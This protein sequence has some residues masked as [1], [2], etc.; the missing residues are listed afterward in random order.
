MPAY[1]G[2][3]PSPLPQAPTENPWAKQLPSLTAAPSY[4]APVPLPPPSG[5][6]AERLAE[7]KEHAADRKT[8]LRAKYRTAIM[9]LAPAMVSGK[10]IS[11][12]EMDGLLALSSEL[13][14]APEQ[15]QADLN[16]A[17]QIPVL[18]QNVIAERQAVADERQERESLGPKL[19][20]A[21][22]LVVNLRHRRNAMQHRAT[23][24]A[25]LAGEL[26]RAV[27]QSPRVFDESFA[28]LDPMS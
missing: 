4:E 23:S 14:F 20:E 19:K 7:L 2:T 28:K 18:K 16:S 5:A 3:L 10:K 21:E 15:M 1:P 9:E 22:A 13:G 17:V 11:A 8:E 6:L 12:K 26:A 27:A 25:M 24:A